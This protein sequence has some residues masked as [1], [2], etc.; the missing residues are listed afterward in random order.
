MVIANNELGCHIITKQ[1]LNSTTEEAEFN[2][3]SLVVNVLP[4]KVVDADVHDIFPVYIFAFP[5]RKLLL[6]I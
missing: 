5:G 6:K 3:S 1:N 4:K 2:F